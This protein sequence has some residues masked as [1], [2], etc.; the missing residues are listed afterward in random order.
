MSV[1][2]GVCILI[3][4]VFFACLVWY[5]IMAVYSGLNEKILWV[6]HHNRKDLARLAERI[7][8]LEGKDE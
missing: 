1:V 2:E 5:L 6:K 3:A 4:F 8:A 7:Q